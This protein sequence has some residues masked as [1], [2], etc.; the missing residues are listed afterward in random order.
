MASKTYGPCSLL[1]VGSE[2]GQEET[3]SS[4]Q[5]S[6]QAWQARE[7]GCCA[8]RKYQQ[9]ETK[10]RQSVE[11]VGQIEEESHEEWTG[12]RGQAKEDGT[13]FGYVQEKDNKQSRQGSVTR[14]KQD[15]WNCCGKANEVAPNENESTKNDQKQEKHNE[16][17]FGIASIGEAC[18][19]VEV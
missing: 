2:H 15:S 6:H 18:E 3:S 1:I 4:C 12:N 5:E 11:E 10:K 16:L 9:A 13:A 7:E 17:D 8:R 19:G 14:T